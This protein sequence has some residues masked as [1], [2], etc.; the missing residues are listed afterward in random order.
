MNHQ[1]KRA[2][3][4]IELLVVIAIIAILASMLLPALSR[5]RLKATG[6]KCLNNQKQL[7]LAWTL[8]SGDWDDKLV[9][10]LL[11]SPNAWISG[12]VMTAVG[13]T[14]VNDIR[15]GKLWQ[16]N[17]A[18]EIYTCPEDKI[19]VDGFNSRVRSFSMSGRMAG[20]PRAAFVNPGVPFF[21]TFSDINNPGPAQA[22]VFV[23]EQ[24]SPKEF[25]N[26][27]ASSI[28]DGFFAVRALPNAWLWQNAPAS[29]HGNKGILSFAD[30]H[31][32]QWSWTE[33]DTSGLIGHNNPAERDHQDLLRFKRATHL[34]ARR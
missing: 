13:A 19:P 28:D 18:L 20:D 3:T 9:P 4:L 24:A 12:N 15:D 33:P 1:N 34:S 27:A 30:G 14:N 22:F 32:E 10:N 17:E 11:N 21:E 26:A 7:A 8:Y 31:A 16:Y 6:I 5:A 29:R 23:D 2:F 25:N